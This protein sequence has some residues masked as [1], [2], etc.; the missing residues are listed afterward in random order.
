M[1]ACRVCSKQCASKADL[2]RHTRIHTGEKPFSCDLCKKTFRINGD[3]T[4]HKK[5]HTGEKPYSCKLCDKHF[6]FSSDLTNHNKS[7]KHLNKMKSNSNTAPTIFFNC[8][9]VIKEE[10]KEEEIFDEDP[11]SIQIKAEN[12][13]ESIK[14]E[15]EETLS[16][17]YNYD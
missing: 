6:T 14:Q 11:L 5:N 7:L 8:G 9:E 16:C 12:I 15:T 17:E 2:A 4:R 1:N 13:M 3:L 10:I